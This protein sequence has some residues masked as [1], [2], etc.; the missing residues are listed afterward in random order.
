MQP[1]ISATGRSQG[2]FWRLNFPDGCNKEICDIVF[3]NPDGF[4]PARTVDIATEIGRMNRQLVQQQ[5][6]YLLIG[7]GRWG[8]ADCWLGIP[9][10]WNDIS[11]VGAI[12]ETTIENFKA[13]PS[14]GSHFFH[15]ITSLG[16]SYL[17][18]SQNGSDFIDW[19]WLQSLPAAEKTTYL[20]H[21]KLDNPLTVK[22]DGKNSKAVI[23]S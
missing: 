2:F 10:K 3:V 18:N 16:I 6:K 12:I 21:V 8:S 19:K 13:D 1:P 17:T 22:I 15:N 14:Q 7:P 5:R 20:H 9:V 11:G 4:D 23:L